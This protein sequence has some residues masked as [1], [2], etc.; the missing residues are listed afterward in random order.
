MSMLRGSVSVC[1][2][3][4]VAGA[5]TH[6]MLPYR[7]SAKARTPVSVCV[8][9]EHRYIGVMRPNHENVRRRRSLNP[10]GPPSFGACVCQ[11]KYAENCAQARECRRRDDRQPSVCVR[12]L[13]QAYVTRS[14]HTIAFISSLCDHRQTNVCSEHSQS[15]NRIHAKSL[16]F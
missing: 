3:P 12:T 2:G 13:W 1:H 15:N 4:R 16:V 14:T 9:V 10:Q 6:I 8:R 5:Y 7:N 11:R